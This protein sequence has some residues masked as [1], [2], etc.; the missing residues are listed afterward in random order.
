MV[1][2]R[3]KKAQL[4]I[5]LA[6]LLGTVIGGLSVYLLNYKKAPSISSIQEVTNE[7][8]KRVKLDAVQHKKAIEILTDARNRRS[9]IYKQIQPQLTIVQDTTRANIR[10]ILNSEQSKEY[11]LWIQELDAKRGQKSHDGASN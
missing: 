8:N 3:R 4:V 2:D 10:S 5:A 7:L 11:D 9:V 6:F 1:T